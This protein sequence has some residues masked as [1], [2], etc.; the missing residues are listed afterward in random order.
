MPAPIPLQPIDDCGEMLQSLGKYSNREEKNV[1]I[2][3]LL[4]PAKSTTHMSPK[5]SK[6]YQKKKP[7]E[8]SYTQRFRSS[9]L[10]RTQQTDPIK[11]AS[12][13][14]HA[15]DS[16]HKSNCPQIIDCTWHKN[17]Q[18][19]R[20]YKSSRRNWKSISESTCELEKLCTEMDTT[21]ETEAH[22]KRYY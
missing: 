3:V 1:S 21:Q 19:Q 6:T 13:A 20:N 17:D 15:A 14:P 9:M 18:R 4:I 11:Q 2:Q 16:I 10:T 22:T 12:V 8:F 7:F 5:K